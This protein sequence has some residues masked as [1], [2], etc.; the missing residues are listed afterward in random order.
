M[1]C[2]LD[3]TKA[4]RNRE[5]SADELFEELGYDKRYNIL[6]DEVLMIG[7]TMNN[8]D[9]EECEI[10]FLKKPKKIILGITLGMQELQAINKKVE[11]L[12]WK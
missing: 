1:D 2:D 6:K 10:I 3:E 9:I 12:G 8:N 5:K 11:E 4:T 7:Y